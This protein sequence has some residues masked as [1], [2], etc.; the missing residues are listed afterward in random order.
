M[1]NL[2]RGRFSIGR[3]K[4]E[5]ARDVRT[6]EPLYLPCNAGYV[7]WVCSQGTHRVLT[8]YTGYAVSA[9]RSLV[10]GLSGNSYYL[11]NLDYKSVCVLSA[12]QEDTE[13]DAIQDTR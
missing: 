1:K 8:G 2:G 11:I 7:H 12:R 3:W 6:S 9:Y 13:Y 5:K 10:H 4:G